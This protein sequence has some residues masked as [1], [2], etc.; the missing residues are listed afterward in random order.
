MA[1][2]ETLQT[3][4]NEYE[5]FDDNELFA[6]LG[7]QLDLID[8]ELPKKDSLSAF[9]PAPRLDQAAL[10]GPMADKFKKIGKRFFDQYS[11]SL[12]ALMCDPNDPDNPVVRKAIESGG[13][14]LA[15]FV[16]GTLAANFAW[17]PAVVALVAAL[18]DQA[19]HQKYV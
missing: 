4:I 6:E 9:S 1:L 3:T 11:K 10:A 18:T 14:Q 19:F 2:S 15:I 17:L 8:E 7:R 12:Y 13:A 16:A 5:K